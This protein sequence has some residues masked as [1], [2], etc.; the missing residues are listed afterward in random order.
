[1]R[2]RLATF[3]FGLFTAFAAPAQP[4][5]TGDLVVGDGATLAG[6]DPV[7]GAQA[8]YGVATANVR[9]VA[10]DAQRRLL[11]LT[12][13]GSIER[14]EPAAYD[15]NDAA[16]NRTAVGLLPGAQGLALDAD[17]TLLVA[18][19]AGDRI[20]RVDPDAFLPG[21]PSAN[22]SPIS[23][24]GLI[25]GPLDVAA[26]ATG[27]VAY[28][29]TTTMVVAIDL[30]ADPGSNQQQVAINPFVWASLAVEAD[31]RVVAAGPFGVARID[32]SAFNPG[33]PT[34]NLSVVAS[35][36]EL[37]QP[38]GLA[39][40][41]G[42]ALV[43]PEDSDGDVVRI[44][45]DAYEPLDPPSN[46]DIVTNFDVAPDL[47]GIAVVPEPGAA[48]LATVAF[49]SLLGFARSRSQLGSSLM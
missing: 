21:D 9:D 4:L 45:P 49:A 42:G 30:A 24:G 1:M 39:V 2:L 34:A 5:A 8:I 6:V 26:D 23:S 11:A 7:S 38:T 3:V 19:G 47:H 40:E 22:Q 46:Q 20:V 28:S 44:F 31:G 10:V 41:A 36:G 17:G 29:T 14:F 33:T 16:A 15:E 12:A 18:D 13:G 32:P 48:A 35:G 37:Q 43:V 25:D 27:D